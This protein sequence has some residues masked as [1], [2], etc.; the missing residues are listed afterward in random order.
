MRSH[1]KFTLHPDLV[2]AIRRSPHTQTELAYPHGLTQ[3]RL[4]QLLH[5]KP[6]GD[7]TRD[8]VVRLGASLGLDERVCTIPHGAWS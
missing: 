6:F 7:K 1:S 2:E 4:S 3:S 5:G 8:P